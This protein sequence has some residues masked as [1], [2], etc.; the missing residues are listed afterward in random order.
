MNQVVEKRQ[1]GW[2]SLLQHEDWWA[3]WLGAVVIISVS[4]GFLSKPTLPGRWGQDGANLLSAIPAEIFAGILLTGFISL[5]LFAV[6]VSFCGKKE[7]SKFLLAF[8]LIFGIGIVAELLGNYSPLRHYGLNNVIWALVLGLLISN[9]ISVPAFVKSAARTELYIKTGLVLLGASILFNRMLALGALGLGVAWLVTPIVLI[10]MYWFSQ[11]YLKMQDQR[12][13]AITIASAT[14][15]CGVS[16]AIA[17]GT[18]ANAKKEEISLAVSVTLIFTVI[19]MVA[20]PVVIRLAG[21]NDMVG[22]AWLGGTI[23]STGAVVAAATMLSEQAVEVASVIKMIQNILIGII[24]FVIAIVWI[25]IEEKG[26]GTSKKEKVSPLEIWTRL[27]K[28]ILG[29][30]LASLVFSFVLPAAVVASVSAPING[31]RDFFF[32]L[33]F[34]SI[35]LETNFKGLVSLIKGGS[36]VTLYIVGQTA[37]LVLTLVAAYIFF[38]GN[39]FPLPY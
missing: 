17:S 24:A 33:A 7:L 39:I 28:F 8:P 16:A 10:F 11:K 36:P 26:D 37:N 22:G 35:G 19:M 15:V 23:D 27:P 20:M 31:F 9:T 25:R 32:T 30:V 29:F 3:V 12:G 1:N 18:A 13:L 6:S 2:S 34:V 5:L 21:I 38:G 4:A 14:S